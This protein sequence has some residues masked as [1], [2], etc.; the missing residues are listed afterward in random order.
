MTDAVADS[1]HSSWIQSVNAIVRGD[2]LNFRAIRIGPTP[3]VLQE[4][5]LASTHLVMSSGKI[6]TARR[7]HPEVALSIWHRLP[8]LLG[9]PLAIFPSARSDGSV[10][11]VLVVRDSDGS[12]VIVP[13]QPG[14]DGAPNVVLSVYGKAAGM[15][16]V[17]A[18]LRQ[19][20]AN[21]VSVF[22]KK[23]SADSVPKPGSAE[24]IPSS[25]GPIPADGS[26]EPKR[27]ILHLRKKSSES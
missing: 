16:W 17:E 23:G 20:R 9:D 18:Q 25:P 8:A 26:T 19:S 5:G 4:F 15:A 11:I 10:I 7:E 27:G 22:K 6:A 1:D 2:S 12:P 21:G 24:A 3:L 14:L 13:I